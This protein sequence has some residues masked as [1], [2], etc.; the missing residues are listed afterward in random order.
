MAARLRGLALLPL[1][2]VDAWRVLSRR[3]PVGGRGRRRLR[4]GAGAGA[5][6]AAPLSD[7]AARAERAARA[8]QPAAGAAGRRRGGELRGGVAR[9]F[10]APASWPA[11]RC[12]RRSSSRRSRR[13]MSRKVRVLIFGGS[14]GAHAINLALVAA[15]P[16][17][18]ASGLDLAITHQTGE[19]D[20]A[21]VRDAYQRA[22]LDARVEAF[23]YEMDREM[24]QADLVVCARRRDH[25]VRAGGGGPARGAGAAADRGRR[26]STEE[27]RGVGPG[28]R[29]GGA[30]RA[31]TDGRTDGGGA[32][33]PGRRSRR[34]G[35]QMG[36]RA[37]GAGAAGCRGPHRRQGERA[38]WVRRAASISSASAG[39]A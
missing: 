8:D 31:R 19:R 27:R 4:V 14:Q 2:A 15:A 3:R 7:A 29:G 17:L 39:S 21:L 5:G 16:Q 22:G 1:S 24:K 11:T 38:C 12:A 32:A 13:G 37:R 9:S 10:R 35:R 26:P 18:A 28:R 25:A 30:R 33:G 36:A 34:G 6:G 23:L 20:L